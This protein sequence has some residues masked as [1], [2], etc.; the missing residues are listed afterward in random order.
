MKTLF[1][2]VLAVSLLV[3]CHANVLFPHQ[4]I[5]MVVGAEGT[6]ASAIYWQQEVEKRYDDAVMLIVHGNTRNGE[7]YAYPDFESPIPMECAVERLKKRF[8][9]RRIVLV[10]C[11]PDGLTFD[12]PGVTY[13][14]ENVY[15]WPDHNVLT[16]LDA[17]YP[18]DGGGIGSIWEF[19]ENP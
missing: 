19:I 7:W 16:D 14:K 15:F 10:A 13:A 8:P 5:T 17:K 6:N 3:G 12:I 11:N 4:E 1:A 2:L 18:E 9:G